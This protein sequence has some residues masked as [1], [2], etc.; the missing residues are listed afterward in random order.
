MISW[1]A[2]WCSKGIDAY[3]VAHKATAHSYRVDI[4]RHSTGQDS[5]FLALR[6][7]DA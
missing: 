1:Q 6:A 5:V 3:L 7:F 4:L 2:T